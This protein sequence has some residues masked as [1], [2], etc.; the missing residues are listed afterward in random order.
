LEGERTVE[1]HIEV[2]KCLPVVLKLLL[3]SD[4]NLS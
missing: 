2:P 3:K 1:I 4:V